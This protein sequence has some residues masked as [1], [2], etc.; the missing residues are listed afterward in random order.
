MRISLISGGKKRYRC[1]YA[2]EARS[3]DELSLNVGDVVIVSI[4]LCKL[5][6]VYNFDLKFLIIKCSVL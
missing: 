2:F 5:S 6:Q 4:L 3:V 1:L